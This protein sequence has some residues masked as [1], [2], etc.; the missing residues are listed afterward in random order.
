M[1]LVDNVLLPFT[2]PDLDDRGDPDG[3]GVKIP[4]YVYDFAPQSELPGPAEDLS[5]ADVVSSYPDLSI[6]VEVPLYRAHDC[7]RALSPIALTARPVPR[8]SVVNSGPTE[9][10]T[11]VSARS[12]L[13]RTHTHTYTHTHVYTRRSPAQACSAQSAMPSQT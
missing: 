2:V 11:H 4:T 9:C 8:K 5:I 10:A 7:H 1:H 3:D 6:L 12:S 13:R